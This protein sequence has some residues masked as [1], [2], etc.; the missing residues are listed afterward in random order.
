MFLVGSFGSLFMGV[1]F[2]VFW[3]LGFVGFCGLVL[4]VSVYTSCVLRGALRF[5]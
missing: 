3:G 1:F 5:H 2:F 4:V